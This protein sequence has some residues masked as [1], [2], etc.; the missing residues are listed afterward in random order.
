MPASVLLVSDHVDGAVYVLTV[1]D[2]TVT[3]RLTGRHLSEHAGFLA[4]PGGRVACVDDRRG[5]LLVLDPFGDE[6]VELAVPVAVPA[7]HLAC[8]PTGRRL[9]VTTGLG[10]NGEPWSDL[11]TVVDLTAGEAARVR[12]RVGEPGVTVLGGGDPLVVLRHR[13]P[14]ALAVHR[15][16]DLLAA[17]PGCPVAVPHALLPLPDDG[18]GDAQD[19]G[20]GRVFAATGT[21]VHTARRKGDGLVAEEVIPWESQARG[22]YLRLDTRRRAL[23][24][25]LRGGDPDPLRWSDWTNQAWCHDLE[26]GRT[27]L[28][29]LGPGLVFRLAFARDHTAFTRIHPD[30]DELVLLGSDGT[31]RR[32]P[33]PAMAGAPKRG[34]TPWEGV[35]RRAVAASPGDHWLAVT[36]GG[37]GE[38]HLVDARTGHE[39]ARVRL[40][41][42]LHHGGHATL[43][44]RNDGA[45][46]DPLGR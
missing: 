4:L 7:E 8:D 15:F 11:L 16:A 44:G 21:G 14:G 36:R 29:D 5:E 22:W 23:W 13:E 19:P 6:L 39:T 1:P 35:Q 10:K 20:P 2:G 30:G 12:T 27:L 33:L 34:G 18:H 28:T 40:D 25:T 38:V 26:T 45:G 17:R 46:G 3:K 42:P 24:S 9:A 32:V 31:L 37:H 41:T 43:L